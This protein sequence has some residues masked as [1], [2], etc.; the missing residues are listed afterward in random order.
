MRI[1]DFRKITYIISGILV[2]GSL[3]VLLIWGLKLG[4]DFTGGSLLEVEYLPAQAG[5]SPRP[6]N[7]AVLDSLAKIGINDAVLQPTGEKGLILRLPDVNEEKHQE[8]LTALGG[9]KIVIDKQFTSIGPTIGKELRRN[10]LWAILAVMLAIVAYIAWAFRHVSRPIASWKY[11]VAALIALVHDVTIPTGI[12]AAL[13]HFYGITVDTLFVTA[14]LTILGFSVHDTIVVFDRVRENL[15]KIGQ[16]E[17]FEEVVERSLRQ[18]ITRSINT[19]LTVM[20]AMFALYIF[21]GLTTKYFALTIL[22]GV[23]FGT[24]SSI[25]IASFILVTWHKFS[26]KRA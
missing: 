22:V 11:G 25:F 26:L 21:G 12:F 23:F 10:S 9:P 7:S 5:I 15:K 14:L 3:L 8:I 17:S 20:F 16:R 18:T 24:Y 2:G 19:S 6:E 13:G 4:I 1:I